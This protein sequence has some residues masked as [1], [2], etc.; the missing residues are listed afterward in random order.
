MGGLS[1]GGS[2]A[3]NPS[4]KKSGVVHKDS[5]PKVAPKA[6]VSGVDPNSK[7][8][9]VATKKPVVEDKTIY[10]EVGLS[11]ATFFSN[12]NDPLCSIKSCE[13][14]KK[15]C[16]EEYTG[17]KLKFDTEAPFSLKALNSE[18]QGWKEEV[19]IICKNS[20]SEIKMDN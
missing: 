12:S 18:I 10:S 6:T 8:K 1:I 7:K 19:C 4:A 13:V 15:G 14:K 2:K 11:A 3:A 5:S 20:V 17:Q 9:V 16:K